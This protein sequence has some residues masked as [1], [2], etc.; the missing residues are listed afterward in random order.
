MTQ[1]LIQ[2][3]DD[4]VAQSTDEKLE[5]PATDRPRRGNALAEWRDGR[6]TWYFD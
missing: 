6:C 2:P 4:L 3:P 1:T 5:V